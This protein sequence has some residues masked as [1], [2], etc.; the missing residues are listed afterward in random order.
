[1]RAGAP[2]EV[3]AGACLWRP[4][5]TSWLGGRLLAAQVPILGG[6]VTAKTTDDV[7]EQLT[8]TVGRMSAP[9]AGAD[10]IDWRPGSADAPL[11]RYGQALDVS[12]IVTSVIT[13]Q[14]WETRVG[15]YQIKDWDD[16][17]AG[18]ITVKAE[19]LIARPRDDKLRTLSSPSG[20]FVS[21]TR[22]M[23]PPGMGV[24][25][26]PAL[27]DRAVPQSMSWSTDRWKNLNELAAAWPALIRV[28][29]WGQ[30]IF[31]APL[32]AVPVPVLTLRDG[33]GGTL[34]SAPRAD[35]R[36]DAYNMI[37]ATSSSTDA[38]DVQGVAAVT[39]GPMSIT[40]PYGAVVKEW[41]S[42]LLEN[43]A[44][45]N[46]AAATMLANSIRPAQSV[47]V[48]IAADPRLQLDD[49]VEILRGADAPLWGWVTGY[50]LPLT[51]KD[52]AMRI[53]V[54]TPS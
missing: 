11:A 52:G 9:E 4:R 3:L 37:V 43:V 49:P 31:R 54:G 50:E 40:G 45:A 53:D 21:E 24:S 28:D 13:G 20:T 5:V 7:L 17:D 10:V 26:D 33:E 48:T 12:I 8:L 51:A 46:A 32:P 14:T 41:S 23:L 35:S 16:D 6:K 44:Q 19:S 1:M 25:F 30:L 47:P 22:R 34:I 42:P 38:A 36:A 39:A 27:I 29:E 15:R 18:L 2:D